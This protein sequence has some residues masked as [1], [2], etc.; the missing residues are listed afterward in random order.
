VTIAGGLLP[1]ASVSVNGST[2]ETGQVGA[3][4]L[5]F[6]LNVDDGMWNLSIVIALAEHDLL[7]T[8]GVNADDVVDL[9]PTGNNDTL[10]ITFDVVAHAISG[11]VTSGLA[12]GSLDGRN[13]EADARIL[14]DVLV[15]FA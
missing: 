12:D 1:A 9:D 5:E 15:D 10:A 14:F 13:G 4:A 8:V 11:E 3:I 2:N 7:E 6:F